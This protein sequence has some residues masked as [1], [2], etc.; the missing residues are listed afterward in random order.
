[1]HHWCTI[2]GVESKARALAFGCGQKAVAEIIFNDL[3]CSNFGTL[4]VFHVEHRADF[5]AL[6]CISA[7]CSTE[8]FSERMQ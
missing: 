2:F 5:F 8:H 1:M 4:P 7:I 6:R 3:D